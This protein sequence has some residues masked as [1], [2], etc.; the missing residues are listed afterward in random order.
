M[1]LLGKARTF[2]LRS[3]HSKYLVADD[4]QETVRQS[5]NGSSRR[6]QWLVERVD[7]K[8]HLIRLKSCHDRYLTAS[9]APFL[10]GM[11]GNKVL[12]TSPDNM[13]E[14]TIEWEPIRHDFKVKFRAFGGSYLRAN[15]GTPPWRNSITHDKPYTN[16]THNWIIWDLEAVDGF[17]KETVPGYIS[18]LSSFSSSFS[19]DLHGSEF[20]YPASVYSFGTPTMSMKKAGMD[21]FHN[22]KAVRFRSDHGKYL[23]AEEDEESVSQNRDGSSKNAR[24]TVEFVEGADDV[25]RLKSCYG[26][27]LTASNLPFLLGM[28][29]R[30]VLQTIP[31]RLDSSLEWE[32][33]KE[34]SRVKLK[35][36]YGQ[37]LR[38]NG[39]PPPW[40]NSVT[41]DV[42]HR[43]STQDW[44]L[45][46]V[47]VVEILL[48][49]SQP[50][51]ESEHEPEPHH[52]LE[53]EVEPESPTQF[54]IPHSQSSSEPSSPSTFISA[55]SASFG[56]QESS[57]SLISTSLQQ[58]ATEQVAGVDGRV[59]Y[60]QIADELGNVDDGAEEGYIIFKGNEIDE[61]REKL[62]EETGLE[63]I[64]VCYRSPLNGKLCPLRLQLPPN[65]ATM[66]VVLVYSSSRVAR[67]FEKL[68][69]HT[70]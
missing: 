45:W 1:E 6:A 31:A 60:Y 53:P 15:G 44:I 19:D 28:T 16:S 63:D 52:Q 39:G 27:Y 33:I 21:L 22:A 64:I 37:F 54:Q 68:G 17:E 62:M 49:F 65:N 67:G 9:Y 26:K 36:R 18:P 29:G 3:H 11:T 7:G 38:A 48:N 4:D 51:A 66:H 56:R 2:R 43:S 58:N 20:E 8:P 69:I 35:T 46:D 42:P 50:P 47:H 23:H 5:R 25:I 55:K 61:M 70:R 59:I 13:K 30:K 24:W 12:Q 40:R 32:P 34:D 57:G 14:P 10:L 41:H